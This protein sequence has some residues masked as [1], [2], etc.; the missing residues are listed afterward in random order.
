ML[1]PLGGALRPYRSLVLTF[2][3][4]DSAMRLSGVLRASERLLGPNR[5][6]LIYPDR[7]NG[8]LTGR[9]RV[10]V[11]H[12]GKRKRGRA[13]SLSGAKVRPIA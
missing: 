6:R 9:Y 2:R 13:S 10:E 11:T 7:K 8:E 5:N 4:P 3:S 12:A 1:K